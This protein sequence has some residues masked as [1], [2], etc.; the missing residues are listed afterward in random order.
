MSRTKRTREERDTSHENYPTPSWAIRA[1]AEHL[2][3]FDAILDPACGDGRIL[4]AL[5]RRWGRECFGIDN[6]PVSWPG[7]VLGDALAIEWPA[8]DLIVTNP[9][10]S[11]AQGFVRKAIAQLGA[12]KAKTVAMLLRMG[13]LEAVG[14]YDWNAA[15]PSRVAVLSPRPSFTDDGGT[16][17]ATYG[18]FLWGEVNTL[19]QVLYRGSV[20]RDYHEERLKREAS[21]ALRAK[22]EEEE[23]LHIET[24]LR[25]ARSKT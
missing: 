16:D 15:H 6:R 1:L 19:P 22:A 18:W 5:S 23:R 2:P 17:G 8:V 7:A 9:P 20:D 21:K 13:W 24:L 11:K 10:Y 25:A 4:D 12:G 3:R 14:N